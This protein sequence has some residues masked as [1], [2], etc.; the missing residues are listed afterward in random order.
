MTKSSG[1]EKTILTIKPNN[2]FFD[3]IDLKREK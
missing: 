2:L 3:E 1:K